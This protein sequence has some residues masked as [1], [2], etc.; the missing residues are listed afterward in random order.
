MAP[1]TQA[2]LHDGGSLLRRA[3]PGGRRVQFRR[4]GRRE[5]RRYRHRVA[6]RCKVAGGT[7]TYALP[8]SSAPNYI[9]PFASST[10]FSTVNFQEFQYM[11]YRPLYWFG[12]GASPTLNSSLS[13]ADPP[14]YN[15]KQ[16]TITLKGW[17]WSNGETVNADDLQF[18]IHMMQ[19]VAPQDW[20]DYVPGLFPDNISNVKVTGPLTL[21]MTMNKAYNPTWFTDNEL[22]QLTP[23]PVAWDKTAAGPS[24]CVNVVADCAKVYAYLDSQ[25]KSLSTW[26]GS[27]LW[28]VVDGPWK[29]A[30][31]NADG[32]STFVPNPDYSGPVKP[33]LAKFEELPFTTESAEY[34][35]LQAGGQ[36]RARRSTSAT[37]PRPTRPPSRPTSPSGRTRS[38]G[39]RWRR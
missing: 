5:P 34:N 15:G 38:T 12:N 28:S 11:I 29:L 23:M 31:F 21:T 3:R 24:N 14:V 25:S 16:V 32:N 2:A 10:Y 13:L 6:Q 37:Y 4:R 27:P 19:A 39:T 22:S 36:A 18:W 7:A 17:K 20:G 30:S 33:T 1:S 9:F 26:V 8:P 35:V